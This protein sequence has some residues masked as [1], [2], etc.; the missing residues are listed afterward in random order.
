MSKAMSLAEARIKLNM[1][2]ASDKEVRA[3]ALKSN[4]QIIDLNLGGFQNTASVSELDNR[5]GGALFGAKTTNSNMSGVSVFD[6][7]QPVSNGNGLSMSG[8]I[9]GDMGVSFSNKSITSIN[10]T[11]NVALKNGKLDSS[12]PMMSVDDLLKNQKLGEIRIENGQVVAYD[13]DGKELT[14]A[15]GQ[16]LNIDASTLRDGI[17]SVKFQNGKVIIQNSDGTVDE[18]R[19]RI[20]ESGFAE[21]GENFDQRLQRYFGISADKY[22]Q[23][24]DEQKKKYSAR[25]QSGIRESAYQ[26]AI[27]QGKSKEEAEKIANNAVIADFRALCRRSKKTPEE[28]KGIAMTLYGLS[29]EDA[30][31]EVE[32]Y[33]KESISKTDALAFAQG[34]TENIDLAD[35][36]EM[37]TSVISAIADAGKTAGI[38]DEVATAIGNAVVS[39]KFH[40]KEATIQALRTQFGLS[41]EQAIEYYK[42]L[43]EDVRQ[44]IEDVAA[45]SISNVAAEYAANGN[46]DAADLST[47]YATLIDNAEYQMQI[48]QSNM[49]YMSQNADAEM[50]EYYS[51]SVANNAYNYNLSNQADVIKMLKEQGYPKTMEALENAKKENDAKIEEQQQAQ[52]AL[53]SIQES[54]QASADANANANANANQTVVDNTS[55]NNKQSTHTVVQRSSVIQHFNP[56]S[57]STTTPEF[58]GFGAS[59]NK[60]GLLGLSSVQ[61]YVMSS[62]FKQADLKTK[63]D[64]ISKLSAGDKKQAI[65]TLVEDSQDYE[66]SKL[67]LSSL[68]KDILRYLVNHPTSKN[69]ESLSYLKG[70]LSGADIKYVKDLNEERKKKVGTEVVAAENRNLGNITQKQNPFKTSAN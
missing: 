19:A 55:S 17:S 15:N 65:S 67:M 66:L 11:D 23:L 22:M 51:T 28:M 41:E 49:D 32:K 45:G 40:G 39:N 8:G 36:P 25:Y 43:P 38:S 57:N 26:K 2:F 52:A 42:N 60:G 12:L 9:Y 21:K 30:A 34:I 29:P 7:N 4:I 35:N 53:K 6:S 18:R 69:R 14:D 37:Q 24:S 59:A 64:F 1:P 58:F 46:K 20:G 62:E 10:P 56:N 27:K 5:L 33:T 47:D 48:I 50:Q 61:T 16:P 31:K 63:E 3:A 68:K 70:F 44:K 13:K 54:Q